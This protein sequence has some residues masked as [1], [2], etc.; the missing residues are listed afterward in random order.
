M[1]HLPLKQRV[2][3]LWQALDHSR[4]EQAAGL[5][6][7]AMAEGAP[8]YGFDP[9]LELRGPEALATR[10]WQ[11]M[12]HAF[13]DLQRHTW[14]LIGGASNGRRDGNR[15]LDDRPWVGGTGVFSGTFAHDWLGIPANGS[16]VSIRWGEFH[17]FEGGRIAESYVLLDLVDLIEQAGFAVL[18]PSRGAPGLYPPPR[19]L[20][21][22]RLGP[23]DPA[24]SE[25]SLDHIWRFIFAGLNA[26]DRSDLASMGMAR[27]FDARVKWYGPGGIGACLSLAQFEDFHQRPWLTAYPDRKVQDLQALI[28]DGPYSGGPGWAGVLATHTGPYL[29]CAATGR[30]IAFNGLDFWK[31]EGDRYIE[32]WVFVDMVHLFRQFGVDLFA[33]LRRPT[34]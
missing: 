33:R 27:W 7:G 11:P 14:I 22:V 16:R 18:P 24:E 8:W 5:F 2:H 21:G 1:N 23:G 30:R 29:D 13:P 34:D 28:A 12:R 19:A 32:N 4:P 17:R 31:R 25:A 20:D 10:W 26:F 6:A 15:A 9:L 3:D